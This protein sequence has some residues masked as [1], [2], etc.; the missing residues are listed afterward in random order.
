[1]IHIKKIFKKKFFLIKKKWTCSLQAGSAHL[2]LATESPILLFYNHTNTHLR[3]HLY[4]KAYE[5]L[6]S[7]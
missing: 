3:H 1:M 4:K 5:V 2:Q 7:D 6:K